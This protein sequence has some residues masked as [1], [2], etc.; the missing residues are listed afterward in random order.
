MVGNQIANRLKQ[1]LCNFTND[2]SDITTITNLVKNNTLITATA[3][4]HGL[5]TGDY[6]TIKGAKRRVNIQSITVVAGV[7][8]I[9]LAESHNLFI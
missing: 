3:T 9:K 8:T 2:F 5:S 7:A 1:V 4:N 6:I